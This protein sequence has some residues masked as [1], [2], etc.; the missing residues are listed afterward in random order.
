MIVVAEKKNKQ[1]NKCRAIVKDD[2]D[3]L[4]GSSIVKGQQM[5]YA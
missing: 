4:S 3:A 2:D 5:A 1:T